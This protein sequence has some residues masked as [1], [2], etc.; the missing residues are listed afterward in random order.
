MPYESLLS[1]SSV[2]LFGRVLSDIQ[3]IQ[4]EYKRPMDP[5]RQSR[6]KLLQ[7]PLADD[8]SCLAR[9]YAFALEGQYYE[10]D[11]PTI[12]VVHGPG[13]DPENLRPYDTSQPKRPIGE[14]ASDFDKIGVALPIGHFAQ[15]MKVWSYDR[16]D[17]SVRLDMSSGMLEQILLAAEIDPDGEYAQFGGGKVGGGKV[18]GG[19]VG[20]GKVGGGKVG[21]GKV[22]GGKVGG[23][24]VGG[25]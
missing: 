18:G 1:G 5:P 20:G 7:T 14:G 25:G 9:I 22:G 23:G 4:Q 13:A 12:F 6:N 15:G 17:Y 11:S 19:K 10:L 16:S 8:Q 3:L 24:K 21:G 2:L